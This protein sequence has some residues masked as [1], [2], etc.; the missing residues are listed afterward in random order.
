VAG[1][2][3]LDQRPDLLADVAVHGKRKRVKPQLRVDDARKYEAR[4][5]ELADNGDVGAIAALVPLY[6][7]TRAGEVVG[8][9]V[10]DPDDR[11]TLLHVGHAKTEAGNRPLAVPR[12]LQPYL[13][14][15]AA[16][17]QPDAPLFTGATPKAKRSLEA[18]TGPVAWL[19]R[20]VVRMCKLAG[21][22]TV[23]PHGLRG[24]HSSLAA[25][26][27]ITST[28]IAQAM[29]HAGTAVT[30]RHYIRPEAIDNARIERVSAALN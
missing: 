13:R 8:R 19:L 14:K 22:P 7:G 26:A 20:Q 30:E 16:G 5:R 21:V 23:G 4:A 18:L 15:L 9:R 17:K 1:G 27:G 11:G 12:V 2:Q 28:A 25:E 6:I 3:G 29:G 10:R 24:T